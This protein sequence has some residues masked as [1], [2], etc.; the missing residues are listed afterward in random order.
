M[1]LVEQHRGSRPEACEVCRYLQLH[2]ELDRMLMHTLTMLAGWM[3]LEDIQALGGGPVSMRSIY[4]EQFAGDSEGR[5]APLEPHHWML[6]LLAAPEIKLTLE[7][8]EDE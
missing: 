4:T 3:L 2:P 8:R 7:L 5:P 1:P 6:A